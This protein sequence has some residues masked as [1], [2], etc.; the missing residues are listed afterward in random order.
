[1]WFPHDWHAYS[2]VGTVESIGSAL[3]WTGER[4]R[5]EH[6]GVV[7]GEHPVGVRLPDPRVQQPGRLRLEVAVPRLAVGQGGGDGDRPAGE[8]A[9]VLVVMPDVGVPGEPRGLL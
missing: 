6:P 7:L 4:L 3:E 5:S 2:Y 9:E 8:E 1:M